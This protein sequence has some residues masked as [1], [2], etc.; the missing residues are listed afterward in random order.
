MKKISKSMSLVLLGLL[1]LPSCCCRDRPHEGVLAALFWRDD[2][3]Y[4]PGYS[5][6]LF[7]GITSGMS[8]ASVTNRLGLPL[9]IIVDSNG[10]NKEMIEIANG[11]ETVSYPDLPPNTTNQVTGMIYYYT[12]PGK[13]S[14][15]WF[16]RAITLSPAGVVSNVHNSSYTD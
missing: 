16:V 2:T 1:L 11:R 10:R 14:D 13:K 3:Q 8:L 5:E 15:H 4:S 9:R 12:K 6:S 7:Q